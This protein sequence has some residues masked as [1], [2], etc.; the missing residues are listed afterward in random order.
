[1]PLDSFRLR[2]LVADIIV[3]RRREAE[4]EAG[5][6]RVSLWSGS[7]IFKRDKNLY[8]QDHSRCT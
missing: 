4:D 3:P 1:M 6:E 7:N 5:P 2:T 8:S